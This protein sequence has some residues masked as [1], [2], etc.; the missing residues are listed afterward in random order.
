MFS[1][2][3]LNSEDLTKYLCRQCTSGL[4]GS[5]DL[6]KYLC[7]Q[8]RSGLDSSLGSTLFAILFLIMSPQQRGG[9]H[10]DLDVDPIGIG[11]G[12]TLSCLHNIL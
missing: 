10:I 9:E 12:I 2:T 1:T 4:D 5:K 11:V 8:C 7:R 6:T 3:I